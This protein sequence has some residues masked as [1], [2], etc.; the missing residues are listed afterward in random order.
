MLTAEKP[1]RFTLHPG[2]LKALSIAI[3][4]CLCAGLWIM[5]PDLFRRHNESLEDDHIELFFHLG[6]VLFTGFFLYFTITKSYQAAHMKSALASLANPPISSRRLGLAILCLTLL[7]PVLGT[8]FVSLR[9]PQIEREVFSNLETIT[10]LNVDLIENWLDERRSDI[11]VLADNSVFV[12]AV[13][14]LRQGN[15]DPRLTDTISRLLRSLY[16]THGHE[17]AALLS[18]EGRVLIGNDH[19][20]LLPDRLIALLPQAAAMRQVMLGEVTLTNDGEA[21]MYIIAP[22]FQNTGENSVLLGFVM[23]CVSLESFIFKHLKNWPTPSPSGETLLV[24]REKNDIVVINT[25]RQQDYPPL[26]LHIPL[27]RTDMP[28]VQAALAA[29]SGLSAGKDYRNI[30]VLAAHRPVAGTAWALLAKIDRNE[31]LAPM[32]RMVFWIGFIALGIIWAIIVLWRQLE[33][34]QTISLLGE[35]AKSDKLLQSFFELPFIGMAIV[36]PE[37]RRF[38]RFNN[39]AT[40]ITGYSSEELLTLSWQDISH[41]DDVVQF[42]PEIARMRRGETDSI[43]FEQRIIRKDGTLIFVNSDVKCIRK[44]DGSLDYL[45]GTVQDITQRKMHEMALSVA[46]AQLKANQTELRIQNEHLRNTKTELEESRSQYISLYEYAP[47]AYLA[48]SPVGHIHKINSTGS[49]LLGIRNDAVAGINFSS[50]VVPDDQERWT[51]FL[52]RATYS[53]ERQQSEFCLSHTDG[54]LFFVNAESSLKSLPDESPVL[55]MTLTDITARRQAEM[56][57]RASIERYEAV[58]QSSNDAIVNTSSKGIIVAW[59]ACAERVFGYSRAEI[60]GQPLVSLIPAYRRELHL[61]DIEHIL[62]G[63]Q[64]KLLEGIVEMPAL[65][66]DGSEF[67]IDLSLT[68]WQVAD[69]VYFTYTIRDITQRKSTEQTLRILSEVVRQSPEAIVI[70]DPQGHIEFVNEAFSV[71]TG[72]SREE[73]IGQNP[74][75]IKSEKTPPET[76]AAMWSAL[77]RGESWRG[78]FYNQRKDGS[79][80]AEFAVVTPIRDKNGEITHYAAI[81]EEI[82]EKKKLNEELESYRFHLEEI[83]GQRTS[84]LAE[85]RVLAEAANIAKS[86]FLANM[87]HEIRTPMNAIVGL[88][89]LLRNSE[90]TPKQIDR[91]DKIESSA[92]HLL[93]IINNILDLSKIEAGKMVLEESNFALASVFDNVRSMIIDQARKKQLKILID[94]GNVPPWLHGDSTRLR[95][96]LLNYAINAVKYTEHG[97][98]TLRAVLLEDRGEE[99]RVRFEAIDSGI[100]IS[101][102]KIPDLFKAFEQA[103]TS[104][105]RKYGGTGLGLAITRRLA[106]L[107]QG[108]V[109]VDSI[110]HCGSTF[111]FTAS[112]KRGQGLMPNVVDQAACNHEDELRRHYAGSR[113]LIADDVEVNL[114]VAQ[115]LLHGVGLQVDSA[116][117]GREAVDKTR[118]TAYDLILMDVQMPEMS[119]LEA[120]RAIRRLYSRSNIP[121]LAMTANAFEEDRNNCLS[122]GMNDFVAKPVDPD[123][124]YAMLLKWL[125]RRNHAQ[126]PV[127]T[128][129]SEIEDEITDAPVFSAIWEKLSA[130]PGLDITNGLARVRGNEEKYIQVIALFLRGHQSDLERLSAALVLNDL[131]S[132]EQITHALKGSAGLIGA[133]R[134]ANQA[135]VLLD[136]IHLKEKR[137]TIDHAFDELAPLLEGLISGLNK[138]LHE[139]E[140]DSTPDTQQSAHERLRDDPMLAQLESLLEEGDLAASALAR[141][142]REHLLSSFGAAG[143]SVLAAIEVFDFERA[144]NE[145]KSARARQEVIDG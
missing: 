122:A 96:A 63:E 12:E 31:V 108:E 16:D 19:T 48:L 33:L 51:E 123:T 34:V 58:T 62:A 44:A 136:T 82:T 71:H 37:S 137:T 21:H 5:G 74:R 1:K 94:L 20:L 104:S 73:V 95:Q 102:E 60:I 145:L 140:A 45:L 124:L 49:A 65:R 69:G 143:I 112:L 110:R 80:F 42:Y 115:L 119:G 135:A 11:K 8:A 14:K 101:S 107:M 6:F 28:S 17:M 138:V 26:S 10:R 81:K 116:K 13:S 89:H 64:N 55:R 72:Y 92:S 46:N 40:L 78:E 3:F 9:I 118:I 67:E 70:T 7:T 38:L 85:A 2:K 77:S 25:L 32:W 125:P 129:R 141:E 114:E 133:S 27:H 53:E 121:V 105:T 144:L 131:S 75:L 98:I 90:A 29:A 99:L 87:S 111:W 24:Q 91:L 35:R 52:E 30:T 113:I 36:S 22:L 103:D 66:K 126:N 132:A 84:Q 79:L 54:T 100:G 68:R 39:Q 61:S 59:N 139:V 109:G 56:A 130:V 57:L 128:D 43:A 97:E 127:I 88:T 47:V 23:N 142:G 41:P 117:T 86:S 83:V 106:E 50:F 18:P 134:V 93:S 76:Y 15:R 120:T 4:Y